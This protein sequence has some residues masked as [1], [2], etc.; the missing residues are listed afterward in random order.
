MI[1]LRKA[2]LHLCPVLLAAPMFVGCGGDPV[3]DERVIATA[4]DEELRWSDLRRVI[5]FGSEPADSAALAQQF[6][7]NWM[8]QQAVLHHAQLNLPASALDFEA[9]LKDYRNS[10]VI[11]AYEQALVQQKLD[12]AITQ[13][14]MEEYHARNSAN[15]G[16][17]RPIVRA[18]WVRINEESKSVL[19]R[20][21]DRFLSGD[22]EK[23]HDLEIW[24]AEKGSQFV[25]R[26]H[27]WITTQELIVDMGLAGS[28]SEGITLQPGRTVH[29]TDR[30]LYLI[31]VLELKQAG[32]TAP[33]ERVSQEIR[34]I[35]INQRKLQL[36]ERMREDLYREALEQQKIQIL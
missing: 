18:R 32:A 11:Y 9:R 36:L 12:T 17:E 27:N 10:L 14:E 1:D 31:E 30:T 5:P 29:R 2:L 16:L 25:D 28:A 21:K 6:I 26:T 35:I 13:Q 7:R 24:L 33:L 4:Y 22:A 19:D 20:A 34:A 15:F 3:D 23:M 8:R